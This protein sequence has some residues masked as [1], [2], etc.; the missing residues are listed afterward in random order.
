MLD[1]SALDWEPLEEFPEAGTLAAAAENKWPAAGVARAGRDRRPGECAH[2]CQ[3]GVKCSVSAV[4]VSVWC[5]CQ[6]DV[7]YCGVNLD[8]QLP[9]GLMLQAACRV[10]G[11]EIYREK[12]L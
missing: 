11:R 9:C 2:H 4:S 10:E 3:C 5:Q 8:A 12:E 1:C 7:S 6:C